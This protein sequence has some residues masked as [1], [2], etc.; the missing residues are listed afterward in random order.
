VKYTRNGSDGSIISEHENIWILVLRNE[1]WG[2]L[3]RSY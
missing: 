3:A 1:R 2:I